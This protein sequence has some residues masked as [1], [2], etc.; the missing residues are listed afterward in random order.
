[1]VPADPEKG[2]GDQKEQ[3][4]A[5]ERRQRVQKQIAR[6]LIKGVFCHDGNKPVTAVLDKADGMC[7]AQL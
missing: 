3:K 1:M 4:I 7:E 5:V 6:R 2:S